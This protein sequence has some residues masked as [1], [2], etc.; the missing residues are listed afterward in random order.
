MA[1]IPE[2]D[3]EYR[4][5]VLG[6]GG[7]GKSCLT[8]QFIQGLFVDD[9]D[10]TIEDSYRKNCHI[11]NEFALLDILDTAGQDDFSAMREQ[12]MRSGEG[13][14]LVYSITSRSSFQFVK[15]LYQQI[16]RTKDK[17]SF[18]VVLVANKSDLE[19]E[20]QVS[21]NEGRELGRRMNC[22]CIET[23]AKLRL[24]VDESFYTIVREIR[25]Y[26]REQQ[27]G[28]PI[29]GRPGS[30]PI[31]SNLPQGFT[32]DD[33]NANCCTGCIIC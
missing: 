32:R 18:P 1:G 25:K 8:L 21:M 14:I 27:I 5:I 28:R 3:R 33:P 12:Y 23:S 4:L 30:G 19:Y 2:S 9:Y 11:D 29:T 15:D 20:R 13:F 17:D 31:N 16:L 26:N 7:V 24:N 22:K 6:D 10:P